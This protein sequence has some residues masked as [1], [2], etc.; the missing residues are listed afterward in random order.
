MKLRNDLNFTIIGAL[1]AHLNAGRKVDPDNVFHSEFMAA[2]R[3]LA[4]NF[5]C[6][7]NALLAENMA[8]FCR[9]LFT[10][11]TNAYWAIEGECL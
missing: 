7:F 9:R 6:C 5:N 8:A 1:K 11:W 3:A 10:H 2:C 4:L